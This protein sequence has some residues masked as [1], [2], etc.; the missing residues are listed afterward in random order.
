[1]LTNSLAHCPYPHRSGEGF[2]ETL[3]REYTD[4]EGEFEFFIHR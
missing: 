4:L 3:F 1:M 2:F